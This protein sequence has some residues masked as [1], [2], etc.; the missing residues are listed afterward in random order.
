MRLALVDVPVVVGAVVG[1]DHLDDLP[2]AGSGPRRA[3]GQHRRFTAGI[4]EADPLQRGNTVA[5]ELDQF[6][7]V[8]A[9]GVVRGTAGELL[10]DG[11]RNGGMSV[12]KDEGA[13]AA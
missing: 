11:L 5:Q 13:P 6:E 10:A 9:G 7:R 12:S 4:G 1:A 2:P 3:H 8:R